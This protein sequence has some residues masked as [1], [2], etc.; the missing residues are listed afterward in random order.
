MDADFIEDIV[1]LIPGSILSKEEEVQI[2]QFLDLIEDISSGEFPLKDD[3]FTQEKRV[4]IWSSLILLMTQIGS[5]EALDIIEMF[6]KGRVREDIFIMS[7][8]LFGLFRN[9]S[10][11]DL[12]LIHI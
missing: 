6:K 9:Y 7:L 3:F 2:E 5:R 1:D 11:L 4:T 12:S 10:S 8:M